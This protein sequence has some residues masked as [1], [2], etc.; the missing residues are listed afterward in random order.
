MSITLA[1]ITFDKNLLCPDLEIDSGAAGSEIET[2]GGGLVIQR[3]VSGGGTRTISL[4]AYYVDGRLY[5]QF[6]LDQIRAIRALRDSGTVVEFNYHGTTHQVVV[7]MGKLDVQPLRNAHNAP[8][9]AV[10][11]GTIPLK[12]C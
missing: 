4:E 6:T 3:L 11:F 5:G 10:Y 9:E 8:G 12:I 1:G 2:L 7:P